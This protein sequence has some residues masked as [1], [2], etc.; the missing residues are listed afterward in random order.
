MTKKLT[1]SQIRKRSIAFAEQTGNALY[2]HFF[3]GTVIPVAKTWGPYSGPG[4][5]YFI[6]IRNMAHGPSVA[7]FY[8]SGLIEVVHFR[9]NG[10]DIA[11]TRALARRL[12]AGNPTPIEQLARISESWRKD[13]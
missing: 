8:E 3:S 13:E 9:P 6:F 11:K 10:P 2:S 1:M 7:Q 4:G 12:A 5:N